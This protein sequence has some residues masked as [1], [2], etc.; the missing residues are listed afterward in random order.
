MPLFQ[1]YWKDFKQVLTQSFNQNISKWNVE[2]VIDMR[3]MFAGAEK[4]N[5]D[6]SVWKVEKVIE[7][8]DFFWNL[9]VTDIKKMPKF[10]N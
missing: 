3:S 10:N 4:F 1:F 6:L 5:Q 8:I 7:Y 2:K 9:G